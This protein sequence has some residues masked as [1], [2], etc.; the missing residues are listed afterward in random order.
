VTAGAAGAACVSPTNGFSAVHL[1]FFASAVGVLIFEAP[2]FE[3][4]PALEVSVFPYRFVLLRMDTA[5]KVS[6]PLHPIIA[7]IE[8]GRRVPKRQL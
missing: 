1:D 3:N 2:G 4:R 6:P 5:I 8:H 7:I